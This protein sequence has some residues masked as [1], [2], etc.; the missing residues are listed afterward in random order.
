MRPD[1]IVVGEFRGGESLDM[2]QA[3]N[4]GH[5]GSLTTV[6]A[7][8]PRDA[9]ARL[10]TLVLM[11]GMDLPLRAIR[12]QI[13]SAIDIIVQITRLKDGSRRVTHITEVH[14]MEGEIVT[15]QDAF[16]LRLRRGLSTTTAASGA[17][18]RPACARGSPSGSRTTASSCRRR[19][20]S[21][22]CAS[23]SGRSDESRILVVGI[24][25]GLL[26]LLVAPLLRD[27][28]AAPRVAA[29]RRLAPGVEHVSTLDEGHRRARPRRSTSAM[30]SDADALFGAERLELA[31]IKID[32]VGS[33]RDRR[34]ARAACSRLSAS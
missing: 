7:N 29:D 15:L 18:S 23:C 3:M 31:G 30:S 27:R 13:A 10:E 17:S 9:L 1:R 2:L 28:T 22:T 21:P 20:S 26:A 8:S 32:A 11:A 5:D 14:G 6:H 19:C 12:E 34:F 16:T 33:S 25:S 4:T 24:A